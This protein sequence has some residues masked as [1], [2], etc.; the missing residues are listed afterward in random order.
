M[1]RVEGLG[2]TEASTSSELGCLAVW[3]PTEDAGLM[4][5]RR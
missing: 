5:K 3:E 4:L 1:P 2:L